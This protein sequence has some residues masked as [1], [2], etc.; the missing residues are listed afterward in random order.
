MRNQQQVAIATLAN[1][2]THFSPFFRV[3][4]PFVAASSA[5]RGSG[6]LSAMIGAF[7]ACALILLKLSPS[8]KCKKWKKSLSD[9][10]FFTPFATSSQTESKD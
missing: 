10:P 6:V 4:A 2:H 3:T 5:S 8:R 1:Q 7:L 9:Q